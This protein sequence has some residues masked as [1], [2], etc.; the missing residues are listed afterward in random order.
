MELVMSLWHSGFWATEAELVGMVGPGV[1]SP[2]SEGAG[3]SRC[4]VFVYK[5]TRD[6]LSVVCCQLSD[7]FHEVVFKPH[8]I[9]RENGLGSLSSQIC[10]LQNE[11]GDFQR[12]EV[13]FPG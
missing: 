7:P 6:R 12:C 9:E 11:K 5:R 4:L 13:I 8:T 1:R 3:E 2:E 10:P